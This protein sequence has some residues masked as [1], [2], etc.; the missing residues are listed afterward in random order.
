MDWLRYSGIWL[1]L[2]FNPFH[3]RIGLIKDMHWAP[4]P[5]R[6]EVAFQFLFLTLRI[7]IDNGD[8]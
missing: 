5:N 6:T 7:V 3:W 2:V 4:S 8:W 1:T